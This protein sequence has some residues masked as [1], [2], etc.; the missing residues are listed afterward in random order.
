M[1]DQQG[2]SFACQRYC[3]LDVCASPGGLPFGPLVE[4][5]WEMGQ[6]VGA[7]RGDDGT[8]DWCHQVYPKVPPSEPASEYCGGKGA[9]TVSGMWALPRRVDAR[10]CECSLRVRSKSK[11]GLTIQG[12]RW[13]PE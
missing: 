3:Y 4:P 12:G 8:N 7:N 2:P 5:S 9:V 6:E 1:F 13:R 11:G 10:S